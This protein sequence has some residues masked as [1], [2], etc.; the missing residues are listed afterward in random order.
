MP[1][2]FQEYYEGRFGIFHCGRSWKDGKCLPRLEYSGIFQWKL[3]GTYKSWCK[4]NFEPSNGTFSEPSQNLPL[5]CS[6]GTDIY[7]IPRIFQEPSV[8]YSEPFVKKFLAGSAGICCAIW[9][10]FPCGVENFVYLLFDK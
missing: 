1:R 9:E 10:L 5:E 4:E 6:Q 2:T 3:P 7:L 8:E